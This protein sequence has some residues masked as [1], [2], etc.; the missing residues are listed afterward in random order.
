MYAAADFLRL[1]NFADVAATKEG[2]KTFSMS[3]YRH[4]SECYFVL[5][6]FSFKMHNGGNFQKQRIAF[7]CPLFGREF[8]NS[9]YCEFKSQK[10]QIN[11][12]DFEYTTAGMDIHHI[13]IFQNS[14]TVTHRILAV[15][16]WCWS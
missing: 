16:W 5:I 2:K 11:I 15:I 9:I 4:E 12:Y 6:S 3:L 14:P 7:I 1:Y 8:E 13:H 10:W